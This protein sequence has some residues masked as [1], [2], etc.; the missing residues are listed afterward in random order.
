[1]TR[2]F[3]AMGYSVKTIKYKVDLKFTAENIAYFG[4]YIADVNRIPM[5]KLKYIDESSFEFGK[6]LPRRGRAVGE[7]ALIAPAPIRGE[8]WSFIIVPLA[9]GAPISLPIG[10]KRWSFIL[11]AIT[12]LIA[13]QFLLPGDVLILDNAPIHASAEIRDE[14]LDALEDAQVRIILLPEYAPELNP[15]ELVLHKL[16][17]SCART[18]VPGPF[19]TASAKRSDASRPAT[20]AH[21]IA[22]PLIVGPVNPKRLTPPTN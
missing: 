7:L 17:V 13:N 5:D 18:S 15:C 10:K 16:S 20:S 12:R 19:C 22:Q 14:L 6:S 1:V 9:V 8:S 11:L 4:T 2:V 3:G 21:T